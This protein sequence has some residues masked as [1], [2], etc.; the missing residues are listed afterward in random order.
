MNKPV[1][2]DES[3]PV[4]I[5]DVEKCNGCGLCVPACPNHAVEMQDNKAM[6]ANPQACEYAG[7]CELICPTQTITWPFLILPMSL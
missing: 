6:V 5:I 3:R 2:F 4:P 1:L 7:E